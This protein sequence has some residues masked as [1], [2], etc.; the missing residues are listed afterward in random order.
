[1]ERPPLVAEPRERPHK[2]RVIFA[3]VA[4]KVPGAPDVQGVMSHDAYFKALEGRLL[5]FC[6]EFL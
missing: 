3:S 1:M 4:V 6:C 2:R 5:L